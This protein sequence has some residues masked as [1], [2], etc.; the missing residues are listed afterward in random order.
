MRTFVLPRLRGWIAGLVVLGALATATF[1]SGATLNDLSDNRRLI[2]F[3][4]VANLNGAL[5]VFAIDAVNLDVVHKWQ[6]SPG[7]AWAD[8]HSMGLQNTTSLS[9]VRNADG[10]VEV[11]AASSGRYVYN[12]QVQP[13]GAWTGWRELARIANGGGGRLTAIDRADGSIEAYLFGGAVWDYFRTSQF[14]PGRWVSPNAW[15]QFGKNILYPTR[16]WTSAGPDETAIRNADGRVEL[17]GINSQ[18][19]IWHRWELTPGG[20]WSSTAF[21][22]PVRAGS[23]DALPVQSGTSIAAASNKD[24][25]LELF[26]ISP[27][28]R[29]HQAW[30]SVAGGPWIGWPLP[31]I[32]GL[33][34][35]ATSLAAI[36]NQDGRLEVFASTQDG[37]IWHASQLSPGGAW[38]SW[39]RLANVV[40]GARK[41]G[42]RAARNLDGRLELFVLDYA[43]TLRHSW[44]LCAGCGWNS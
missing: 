24:G 4:V 38:S 1:A 22:S 40:A 29:V 34:L 10:R 20:G 43:G 19:H 18:N 13:S 2:D 5:E 33:T 39:N 17:F 3:R 37:T 41:F 35:P 6:V 30:Q 15:L 14:S 8:W 32:T 44:Q 12:V 36:G 7:G 26:Y 23:N 31:W 11:H 28:A 27:D 25:R 9:A 42:L 16:E 21:L